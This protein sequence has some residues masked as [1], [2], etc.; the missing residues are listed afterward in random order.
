MAT[1]G[2]L[3]ATHGA[4]VVPGPGALPEGVSQATANYRATTPSNGT[5]A[6]EPHSLRLW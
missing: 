2:T 4:I 3:Q 1:P 6:W 5:A